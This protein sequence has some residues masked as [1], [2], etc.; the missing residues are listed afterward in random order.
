MLKAIKTTVLTTARRTGVMARLRDSGWRRRRLLILGYHGVS[1]RDEHEWDGALYMSPEAVRARF[2]ALRDGGYQV[3]PLAAAI[4]HLA[5]GTLPP[6]AVA[7][8]FDD[9]TYDFYARAYPL[10][11]EFGY[12][13]TVYLTSYYCDFQRPVFNTTCRYFLWKG[14]GRTIDATG[15]VPGARSFDLTTPEGTD[16][17]FQDILGAVVAGGLSA[18]DK[19]AV[20][21]T[22]A[23]RVGVD[24]AE[25]LASRMLHLMRPEEV[26]QLSPELVDVQLHT[27]RHRVPLE[28]DAFLREL[29]DNR[30]RIT[31]YTH[32][33]RPLRH[34]CYP[35]GVTD[36]RFLPWLRDC[37]VI[38]ATTCF[39]GMASPH[40]DPLMLP[41]LIDTSSLRPVEFEG[42]LTGVSAFLPRRPVRAEA[43]LGS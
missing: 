6:R 24:Y 27:H 4:E 35:S 16:R 8:T 31:D 11:Q 5:R 34:F 39:P 21:A 42:W 19:D 15:I 2:V 20:L 14:R 38:S 32:R 10:L 9:G 7:L 37:D 18:T 28:R 30:A 26:R 33:T 29:A 17:A 36:P 3:L 1:L 22:L 23:E 43:V 13:A 12:P 41:R 25:L 40:S